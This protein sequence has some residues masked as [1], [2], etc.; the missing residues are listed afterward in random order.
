MADFALTEAERMV[1]RMAHEFAAN[2][3]RPV[4][5]EFD[6]REEFP[7]DV[8]RKG[9]AL[10][11]SGGAWG[12]PDAGEIG[13]T[14]LLIAE[15]LAWGCGGFATAM[16]GNGLAATAINV[17]GT[18]EQRARWLPRCTPVDGELHLGA[19]GLTEPESGSD[20]GG[21][22]TTAVRDGDDYVLNGSKRF[23]TGG[24]ISEIHVIFA[25]EE[26]GTGFKGVSAFVV[27]TDTEGFSEGTVWKKMGIR[28]SHTADLILDNVRIPADHRLGAPEPDFRSGG[29]GAL[30]TLLATRPWIAAMAIGIGRAAFE[31]AAEYARERKQFGRPIIENQGV[32]FML[33]DM[34]I[35][36]D[37]ARLLTWR[38]GWMIARGDPCT[39]E[40]ASKAKAFAADTTMKV[41]TDAVQVCGGLGFMREVPVEKW[42]RDAKIFQIYEGTSQIQREVIAR[43]IAQRQF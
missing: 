26:P 38:A 29:R 14:S 34:D 42:M 25:T 22:Q 35:N 31:Y 7:W 8:A 41:T 39:L 1:Q 16:L 30:G 36:L 15:E 13:I 6:E 12:G 24:G 43:N 11:L 21:L 3:I 40:E 18:D 28:A 32:G 10:G 37:A 23:I 4:A 19:L 27:P 5:A 33:A 2:E 9:A 20:A 17:I